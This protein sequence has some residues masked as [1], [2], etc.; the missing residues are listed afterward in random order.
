MS[1]AVLTL[2]VAST[3]PRSGRLLVERGA[4]P[5]ARN[6]VGRLPAP[7][8]WL[9]NTPSHHRVHHGTNPG[10]L[11]RNYGGVFIIWDRLF[12]T[13]TPETERP[14]YGIIH[15]LASF[16]PLWVAV[17]EWVGIARDAARARTPKALATAL[18]G[19]PGAVTGETSDAIRAA[20]PHAQPAE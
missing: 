2:A 11:D 8:E 18:F 12:G 9:F 15:N 13:F 20:S 5:R 16:N 7:I 10:Y 14:R 6:V 3:T 19:P 17:H 1:T 4:D